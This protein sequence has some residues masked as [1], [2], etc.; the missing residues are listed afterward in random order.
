M[1]SMDLAPRSSPCKFQGLLVRRRA[2]VTREGREG[3]HLPLPVLITTGGLRP[4]CIRPNA[5]R[6][7]RKRPSPLLSLPP[8]GKAS[9]PECTPAKTGALAKADPAVDVLI[10][11]RSQ[12]PQSGD[13]KILEGGDV[14]EQLPSQLPLEGKFSDESVQTSPTV[15]ALGDTLLPKLPVIEPEM[16]A[17]GI[18]QTAEPSYAAGEDKSEKRGFFQFGAIWVLFVLGG[19]YLHHSATGYSV[20]AMLPLISSDLDLSDNQGA[21]LTLGYTILY[22]V[23]LIP[24][25][26]LADQVNR[27]RLLGGGITLWSAL[28]SLSSRV[29]SFRDLLLLRVGFASAQATM[30][31]VCFNLIPEIFPKHKSTALAFYNSAVYIGRALS[32]AFVVILGRLGLSGEVGIKMIPLDQLD[33]LNMELLYTTGDRAAV[34]PMYDYNFQML[35]NE[36]VGSS[37]R[38]VLL[39][40]GLPGLA[41]AAV[42]ALTIAEPR[43]QNI[44]V[45]EESMESTAAGV[46]PAHKA[47]K[48]PLDA[49]SAGMTVMSGVEEEEHHDFS[50]I[51]EVLKT[52]AFLA[53]TLGGTLND[54]GGWGLAAWHATFYE[55]VFDL[56]AE[57]YAPLLAA[58][59]PIGGIV[60]GVGGG[61]IADRVSKNGQ[62]YWLTF[63]ATALAAPLM[64]GSF[65]AN[66][67]ERSFLFLLFGFALSEAWRAPAAVMVRDVA[68][69]D[70]ASS[71]TAAN[72]SLRNMV[73][74]LGPLAISV[75]SKKFGLQYAMWLIPSC[76]LLSGVAFLVAEVVLADSAK[77]M[78]Q[79]GRTS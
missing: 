60:G 59:I 73:A 39:W 22:A 63:G 69:P 24:M 28:T 50:S 16:G 38:D 25:G 14:A 66:E 62:R 68:P 77:E 75:L 9:A 19:A 70:L 53:I 55:R 44:H 11:G 29:E 20:P 49:K 3:P 52:P 51:L 5:Y 67:Y 45:I 41:I 56:P 34:M 27:P 36:N 31:P 79:Q 78:K 47:Q 32:F 64:L 48:P 71:A 1:A 33:T 15:L 4:S 8:D 72:L 61:L 18:G 7:G 12:G 42:V 46:E 65:N 26:Y 10:E 37:W 74:G 58:V 6:E 35:F 43:E 54:I 30:N 21:F 76:Y 2:A 13:T 40:L 17:G 23:S 57:T